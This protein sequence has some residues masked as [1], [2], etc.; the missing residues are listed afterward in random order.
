MPDEPKGRD[1]AREFLKT[2]GKD[3]EKF[4]PKDKKPPES[5]N[6]DAAASAETKKT[7]EEQATEKARQEQERITRE[8]E[9]KK[10]VEAEEKR[11]LEAKEE[12]LTPEDR[13]KKRE[14]VA[15]K[16]TEREAK[17]D[18][19]VQKRIDELVGEIKT[20]KAD[21]HQDKE[22][23]TRLGQELTELKTKKEKN[24]ERIKQEVGRL[25]SERV[26][27]YL[28]EDAN[29]PYAERREM[30]KEELD[31][32]LVEDLGAAQEWIAERALRR[33]E[34]RTEDAQ[35][36]AKGEQ[37]EETKS[38]ASTVVAKQRESQARVSSRHP[39][40]SAAS[41]KAAQLKAAGKSPEEV[42]RA[43][44]QEFP[45]AKIVTEIL[46]EDADK[47]ML[48]EDGPELLATEME[49]RM[50]A[51]GGGTSRD[52]QIADEAAEAERQR[53]ADVDAGF[54]PK[55][56]GAGDNSSGSEFEKENPGMYKQHLNIWRKNL[57]KLSETE[58]RSRLDKR[59]KERRALGAI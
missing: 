43:I 20:L 22:A 54:T 15:L 11:L 24:P 40:L 35:R 41:N 29:L 12:E 57:P 14:V 58:L 23:I 38:R 5:S 2:Q 4:L 48:S 49:R 18:A 37:E 27:K 30:T 33:R 10:Q 31:E 44:F 46:K 21:K 47:Y 36:L 59:L 50:E 51:Q 8:A 45:K 55:G 19:S 9:T 13:T 7:T 56:A 26:G 42:Q 52:Q 34:D 53:Q 6:A 3:P 16:Q 39:E 32:F 17:R 1:K 28:R 25:E